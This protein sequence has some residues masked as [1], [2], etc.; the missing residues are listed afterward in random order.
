MT[1]VSSYSYFFIA[2]RTVE[3]YCFWCIMVNQKCLYIK[4]RKMEFLLQRDFTD[5]IR[6]YFHMRR[7]NALPYFP[8]GE[9]WKR[10]LSRK[11]FQSPDMIYMIVCY[12]YAH[13]GLH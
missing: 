6:R 3:S 2:G 12:Q 7:V 4:T 5:T 13:Y 11:N 10:V 1:K 8:G 9:G